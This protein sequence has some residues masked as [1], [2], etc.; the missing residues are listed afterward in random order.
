MNISFEHGKQKGAVMGRKSTAWP[1]LS[2]QRRV[3][4][5]SKA[6]HQPFKPGGFTEDLV[7]N[8]GPRGIY[9]D[10]GLKA[11]KGQ[12][13]GSCNRRDCQE[14]GAVF[15]NRG[16]YAYYCGPC[17]RMINDAYR[18]DLGDEPLCS[19]D[20]EAVQLLAEKH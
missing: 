4:A 3:Q 9:E 1:S 7:M 11:D 2:S 12:K 19:L 15:Y 10:K 20:E 8:I 16:S 17:A 6:K 5:V 14:P 13:A 18:G